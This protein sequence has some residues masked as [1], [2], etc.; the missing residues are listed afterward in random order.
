M[1]E[2]RDRITV[3]DVDT[4]ESYE[5]R[6]DGCFAGY[7]TDDELDDEPGWDR[8]GVWYS[9]EPL[10]ADHQALYRIDPNPTGV[11]LSNSDL[12]LV[13]ACIERCETDLSVNAGYLGADDKT[14]DRRRQ[15]GALKQN[16]EAVLEQRRATAR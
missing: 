1:T 16:V 9:D 13:V 7:P 11:S 6:F 12:A 5:L 15:L 14:K 3:I 2:P 10:P 4:N 8:S